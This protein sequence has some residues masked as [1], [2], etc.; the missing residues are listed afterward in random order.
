[1]PKKLGILGR[2]I[3]AFGKLMI[4]FHR[5]IELTK[6]NAVVTYRDDMTTSQIMFLNETKQ[7]IEIA[8]NVSDNIDRFH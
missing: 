3:E 5:Y 6:A 8:V 4:K 1:M 7:R 2:K